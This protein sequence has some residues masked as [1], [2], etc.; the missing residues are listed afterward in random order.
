[1]SGQLFAQS[2][3]GQRIEGQQQ[4]QY[5][6]EY[7]SLGYAG[8]REAGVRA[9]SGGSA[10]EGS[11]M[12]PREVIKQDYYAVEKRIQYYKEVIPEKKIEMVPVERKVKRYEY[13]PVEK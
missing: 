2:R 1:M 12:V 10:W 8:T 6:S 11:E 7:D 13:V 5:I 3:A 9:H 4:V